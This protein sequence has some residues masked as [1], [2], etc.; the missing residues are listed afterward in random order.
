MAWAAL[1]LEHY[2][3]ACEAA[4]ESLAIESKY[5][6][7]SFWPETLR[8]VA[9]ILHG[10]K[11]TGRALELQRLTETVQ[12][13]D[14]EK[15]VKEVLEELGCSTSAEQSAPA[16]LLVDSLSAR[17]LEVLRLVANGL[18]NAEIAQ[19]LSLSIGTV[20]VHSRNIYGKLGVNSRTQAIM[21]AH[22]SGLL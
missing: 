2:A 17:E 7:V 9:F 22:K 1:R 16:Q 14:M 10:Q 21:E 8:L 3:K 13:K 12:A 6:M 18:S 20:K 19:K 15:A 5:H 4:R 11:K